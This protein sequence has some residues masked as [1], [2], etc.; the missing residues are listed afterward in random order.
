M[1]S[2]TMLALEQKFL[3]HVALYSLS[4][5]TNEEFEFR[6][7]LFAEQEMSINAINADP[8][9]TFTVAHNEFSTWTTA[10][11]KK[12]LGDRQD[13]ISEEFTLLDDSNLESSV[14]WRSKGAVNAVKNQKSCG[15]CWAFSATAALEGAHFIKTGKLLSLSEQQMVDCYT[16]GSHGC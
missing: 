12:L 1:L 16:S 3:E 13:E 4:Y 2:T 8:E 6:Q 7:S 11:Y 5:G 10:E 14:D 15:S 9:N